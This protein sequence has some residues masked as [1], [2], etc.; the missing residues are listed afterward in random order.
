KLNNLVSELLEVS[1]I[2]KSSQV[3]T[4]TRSSD[5]WIF[6]SAS[7]KGKGAVTIALDPVAKTDAVVLRDA[8]ANT[9]S[10]AM[11]FVAKGEHTLRVECK[12]K[13]R[14]EKLVVKA[15]PELIHCGLGFD[16]QI[17]SYGHY[18]MDFLRKDIL[19]NVTT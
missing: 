16:P 19:P 7:C 15:I 4:F 8:D 18:D 9:L 14:V 2:S 13:A 17:K 1:S 6:V 5:G 12:G 11:R 10:E 3:F